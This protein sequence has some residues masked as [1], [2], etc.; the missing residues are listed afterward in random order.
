MIF[1]EEVLQVLENA[2]NGISSLDKIVKSEVFEKVIDAI[3]YTKGKIIISGVGKSGF[4]ARKFAATLCSFG[5]QAIFLSPT[6]ASHGD[7][8]VISN[9]DTVI[10]LSKSGYTIE[11]QDIIKYC[12][13]VKVPIISITMDENSFLAK[14]SNITMVL[15]NLP[16][17]FMQINAPMSSM[18]TFLTLGDAISTSIAIKNNLDREKYRLYHPGGKLGKS[19][20]KIKYIM[21][22][23]DKIPLV[24]EDETI[25]NTILEM[26]AKMLGFTAVGTLESPKGII[27]DGDLRRFMSQKTDDKKYAK[28][29]MTKNFKYVTVEMFLNETAQFLTQNKI[30][31]TVVLNDKGEISG[32][33]NIHDLLS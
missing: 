4:I 13:S 28:D 22:T 24:S 30:T 1:L 32:A 25:D 31:S 2:K 27:T 6:D 3:Y 14:E 33:V 17:G 7:L 8:G 26:N 18:T 19:M 16:D 12:Q 10:L 11:L 20:T 23:G 29:I 21:R 9:D 5:K 15:P